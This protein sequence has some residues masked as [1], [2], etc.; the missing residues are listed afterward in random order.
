MAPDYATGY[1]LTM[2]PLI[3]KDKVV[4]GIARRRVR[5]RRIRRGLR[6]RRPENR[7]GASTPSPAPASLATTPGRPTPGSTAGL[8]VGDRIVRS[9]PQP[10]VLGRRQSRARLEPDQREGDNL[11]SSIRS[12][13]S[14]PTRASSKW[15]YQF[16]PNDGY[17]Y[18][19]VQIPVLVDMDWS[20]SPRKVMLWGNRNGFFYVLDRTTGRFLLGR[21]FVKVNWASGL[22]ANGRPIQT[23]QPAG[24]P[25]Y[26]GI[27]GG[28]TGIR[29]RTVRA[30]DCSTCRSGT[31]TGASTDRATRIRAG[32]FRRRLYGSH[33]RRRARHRHRPP[34]TDQQLDQRGRQRRVIAIDPHTGQRK[35]KFPQFDVTEA[36]ILTTASDV[37]FTGGREGYF[38]ALDARTGKLLWRAS[39]GG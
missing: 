26:P 1:S 35:W 11:Y 17:D 27:K 37:L 38:Q 6:G 22:D 28:R 32:R 16:T 5:D 8:R 23:P 14:M 36:G 31:T 21:P 15:H 25:T 9:G 4:I 29:R 7:H 20:G 30:P 34:Q 2:A 24:M 39:L 18:D 13:R 10:D 19:S 12:S 33:R 3:I